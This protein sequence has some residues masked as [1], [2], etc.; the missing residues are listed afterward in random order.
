[1]RKVVLLAASILAGL[2]ATAE[3]Q[4]GALFSLGVDGVLHEPRGRLGSSV[5]PGLLVRLRLKPGLGPAVAVGGFRSG[6]DNAADGELRVRTLLAGPAYRVERGRVSVSASLL[7]GWAF[8]QLEAGSRGSRVSGSRALQPSVGVWYDL[9]DSLGVRASAGY[10]L[11]R[12][13]MTSDGPAGLRTTRVRADAFV[14][15]V[16]VAYAVF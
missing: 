14:L 10:L 3:A 16:G 13:T 11:T 2:A 6:W 4:S 9:N 7:A 5:R 12:P 15:R 1:M 8:N